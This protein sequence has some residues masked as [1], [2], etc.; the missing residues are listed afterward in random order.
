MKYKVKTFREGDSRKIVFS[1]DNTFKTF[2]VVD[3]EKAKEKVKTEPEY[4]LFSTDKIGLS[5]G[6]IDEEK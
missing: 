5:W 1:A 3:R 6:F 2:F 4:K